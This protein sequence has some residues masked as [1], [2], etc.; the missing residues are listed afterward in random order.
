MSSRH[1]NDRITHY[2][3]ESYVLYVCITSYTLLPWQPYSA[4]II[5]IVDHST[6]GS[7]FCDT[8]KS[9]KGS[10]LDGADA[11]LVEEA[12]SHGGEVV[13]WGAAAQTGHSLPRLLQGSHQP[14]TGTNDSS[15]G[16]I[17]LLQAQML[18]PHK[19]YTY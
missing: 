16:N 11:V 5:R 10:R 12:A 19:L 3:M 17:W 1:G 18:Q 15:L 14:T 13:R 4:F 7:H 6:L 2:I 9:A 8:G